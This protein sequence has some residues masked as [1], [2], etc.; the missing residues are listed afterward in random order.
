MKSNVLLSTLPVLL[1]MLVF[2]GY[3]K[4]QAFELGV[5][6][7]EHRHYYHN[8][9]VQ[10]RTSDPVYS[11]WYPD[12]SSAYVYSPSSTVY[13]DDSSSYG[14]STPYVY[15]TESRDYDGW[16]G[17]G[18]SGRGGNYRRDR[19]MHSGGAREG[20]RRGSGGSGFRR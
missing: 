7:G 13:V 14:Y 12:N 4:A 1:A 2:T 20:D 11:T 8:N 6:V 5:N 17:S 15:S 19:D 18:R 3:G 16:Y 10:Y 9:V